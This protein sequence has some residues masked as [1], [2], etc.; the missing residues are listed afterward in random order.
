MHDLAAPV[1]FLDVVRHR[2]L[3]GP[4]PIHIHLISTFSLSSRSHSIVSRLHISLIC[5][6]FASSNLSSLP[7][8][9]D[10]NDHLNDLPSGVSS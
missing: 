7:L 5:S 9:P 6:M 4:Q 8:P 3:P 2:L 1:R 10:P